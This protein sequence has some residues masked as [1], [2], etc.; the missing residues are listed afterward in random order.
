MS[1]CHCPNSLPFCLYSTALLHRACLLNMPHLALRYIDSFCIQTLCCNVQLIQRRCS[2]CDGSGLVERGP[3]LRK[4]PECGGFFPWQGWKRFLTS[5]ATPGNGGVLRQP[6][7]QDG[8]IYKYAL[9]WPAHKLS[10]C[11][12]CRQLSL[13]TISAQLY[14]R[15]ATCYDI[16]A[17]VIAPS[18][19]GTSLPFCFCRHQSFK[20]VQSFMQ[21]TTQSQ[22]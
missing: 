9:Q 11:C 17:S 20:H 5:T 6:R 8:V 16:T 10:E 12:L 1:A 13:C 22:R 19:V 3:F 7:N 14:V 15:Q 21:D 18:S 4:C 2:R